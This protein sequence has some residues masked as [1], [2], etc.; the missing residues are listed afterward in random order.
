MQF[1]LFNIVNC[2][3]SYYELIEQHG[4]LN[5]LADIRIET[6]YLIQVQLIFNQIHHEK[7][8][9][10]RQT[11]EQF[12]I[13]LQ[14]LFQIPLN[15]LRVF[16]IDEITLTTGLGRAEELKYPQRFLHTYVDSREAFVVFSSN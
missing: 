9:D 2:C 11:V 5:P 14:E 15:R 16:Y 7:F 6:V 13:Y 10:V 3:F 4:Q 1:F 8:I 12:K